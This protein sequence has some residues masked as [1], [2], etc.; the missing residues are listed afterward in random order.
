VPRKYWNRHRD[1][2]DTRK[3]EIIRYYQQHGATAVQKKYKLG[4]STVYKWLKEKGIPHNG[5][6]RNLTPQEGNGRAQL[7]PES[8]PTPKI[9]RQQEALIYLEKWTAV[10]L[11]EIRAGTSPRPYDVYAELALL[12][13]QGKSV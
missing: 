10:R 7:A 4:S 12:A 6:L 5:M 2:T 13:L 8:T 11:N 9:T 3:A 1:Y